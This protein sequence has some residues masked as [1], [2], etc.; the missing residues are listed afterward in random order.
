[1]PKTTVSTFNG[2]TQTAGV[3]TSLIISTNSFPSIKTVYGYANG[4]VTP[5]AVQYF[6]QLFNQATVPANGTV[7]LASLQV[8]SSDGFVFDWVDFGLSTG[9]LTKTLGS[10]GWILCLS[11]TE[12]TLTI[13]TGNVTMD[14]NVD[15]D[16]YIV[17]VRGLIKYGPATGPTQ[18]IWSNAQGVAGTYSRLFSLKVTEL[19][20]ANRFIQVFNDI[21]TG[22]LV[23]ANNIPLIPLAANSTV[24]LSF[25]GGIVMFGVNRSYVQK[26]GCFIYILDSIPTFD[27][28]VTPAQISNANVTANSAS[29]T[30]FYL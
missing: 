19:L 5:G 15:F 21:T 2:V 25:S 30:A 20:G 22:D 1:M 18:Q 7:P 24:N 11:T 28:T 13:G 8:L 3:S 16:S 6:L 4:N 12:A 29:V 9:N 23:P 27:N 17:P 14:C 26:R 10:S